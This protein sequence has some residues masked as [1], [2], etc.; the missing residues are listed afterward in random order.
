M[1]SESQIVAVPSAADSWTDFTNFSV[2]AGVSRLVKVR[3]AVAPDWGTTAGSVRCAPVFRLTGSGL[4]EQ[5]P[6]EYL[7]MFAGHAEVTTGGITQ[8]LLTAEYDVDI[9]VQ[10]GGVVTV[11]VNTLDEAV[12]AG[13]CLVNLFYDA[14]NVVQTNS[15]SQYVDSAGTT[16]ADAWATVGTIVVPA[17]QE[18][19]KP[20]RI[21]RIGMG[22]AVDQGTSAIS[23][24]CA[25][26]FRL[27]GSGIGEG[28][29]H[30]YV[31]PVAFTGEIGTTPS[32]GIAQD[33]GTV[34]IDVDVPVNA[35]GSILVEH[36]YDVETPTAST[37]A[38][39]L[40]YE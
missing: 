38:V 19:N 21:K 10:T 13:T 37:V 27:S 24:R 29:S 35:S 28:G 20:K 2:P 1:Q 25:S 31:G 7:G 39:V 30:D 40:V 34:W 9:P 33:N 16:T 23:L 18:G 32:Q 22:V 8:T 15:Q 3:M 4:L 36:R 11:Q 12:T 26:R 6:H 17:P 5:S 14:G